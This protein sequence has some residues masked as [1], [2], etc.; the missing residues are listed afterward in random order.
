M[1]ASAGCVAAPTVRYGG[2]GV[3]PTK[4]NPSGFLF[5]ENRPGCRKGTT[6]HC[7][8]LLVDNNGS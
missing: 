7:L 8:P 1:K 4:Q 2:F 3:L 6:R 5:G